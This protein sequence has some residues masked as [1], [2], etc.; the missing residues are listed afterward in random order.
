MKKSVIPTLIPGND[1]EAK[2]VKISPDGAKV[3]LA[4]GL[5]AFVQNIHLTEVPLKNP[6][7]K[8][9]VG[10]KLHCKVSVDCR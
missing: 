10:N 6:E 7:K 4:S 5:H 2:I 1:I 8:L 3:K 9:T